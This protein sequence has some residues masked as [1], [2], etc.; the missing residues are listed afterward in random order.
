MRANDK[1]FQDPN[2]AGRVRFIVNGDPGMKKYPEILRL[3]L[4]MHEKIREAM[5]K[6]AADVLEE[7]GWCPNGFSGPEMVLVDPNARLT[8]HF[9]V[10]CKP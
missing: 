6:H 10:D 7:R 4:P 9:F 1:V 2:T 5:R 8:S 3:Q